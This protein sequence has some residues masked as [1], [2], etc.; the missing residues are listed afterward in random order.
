M[1]KNFMLLSACLSG[2]VVFLVV[3]GT[4]ALKVQTWEIAWNPPTLGM[5]MLAT[6]GG[7]V[8][9]GAG[10]GV[11][12]APILTALRRILPGASK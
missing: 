4:F 9:F 2:L 7:L 3:M 1:T 10:L 5:V 11:D 12:L 8:A 6:A